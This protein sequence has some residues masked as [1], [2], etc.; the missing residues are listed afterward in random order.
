[1]TNK[2]LTLPPTSLQLLLCL[3]FLAF[4]EWSCSTSK[5][6][7]DQNAF[8]IVKATSQPWA[9]GEI[10]A[11]TGVDYKV[12]LVVDQQN[13][14]FDSLWTEQHQ[15]PV[16][17]VFRPNQY[18]QPPYS[19]GDTVMLKARWNKGTGGDQSSQQNASRSF[20]GAGL[21]KYQQ[22]GEAHYAI[23]DTFKKL[24][25]VHYPTQN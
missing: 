11:G 25:K 12:L 18:A 6:T 4:G 21:L 19:E 23:I 20:D 1:M 17:P 13:I 10:G 14:G 22:Q 9:G 2:L 8:T 24:P 5:Q 7:T 3:S 15:L 16:K